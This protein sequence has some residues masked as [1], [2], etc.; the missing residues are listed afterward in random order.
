M[1]PHRYSVSLVR[2][3]II[4]RCGDSFTANVMGSFKPAV[5]IKLNVGGGEGSQLAAFDR[6][7]QAP[8][9]Y[10]VERVLRP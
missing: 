6:Q 2:G 1:R 4:V 7:P 8:T 10:P 9:R 3:L 5:P